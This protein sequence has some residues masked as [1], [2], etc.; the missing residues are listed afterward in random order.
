MSLT[1]NMG[2]TLTRHFTVRYSNGDWQNK[3]SAHLDQLHIQELF[4][5][6]FNAID[7]HNAKRQGGTSFEDTWKAHSYLVC[8]K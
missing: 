2:N 8:Q 6:N 4:H 1:T 3:K 5:F 7:K